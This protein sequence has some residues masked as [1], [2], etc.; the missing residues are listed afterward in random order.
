[1]IWLLRIL[2]LPVILGCIVISAVFAFEFGWTK[3]ATDVHRWAFALAGGGLDFLKAAM[4]II[5]ATAFASRDKAKGRAAWFVFAW[6]TAISLW[7]AYGTTAGQLAER[8]GNKAVEISKQADAKS[9]RDRLKAERA[10]MPA[11]EI[12]TVDSIQAADSAVQA[13]QNAVEAADKAVTQECGRVGDNCRK[14]QGEA[15]DRRA[16]LGKAITAKTA[17]IRDKGATDKAADLEQQ[18]KAAEAALAKVDV[19]TMSVEADPQSASMSKATGWD[20]NKIVLFS[21]LLFA[22]GI[23]AGSGFGLWMLMGH[24]IAKRDEDEEDPI[25]P[26]LP[27]VAASNPV[28]D[29]TPVFG[30][31]AHFFKEA[32][33]PDDGKRVAS[34]IMYRGYQA[35]CQK[36][37]V[38]PL[39]P[40]VFGKDSPWPKEKVGGTVYYM[41]AI[42][43]PGYDA[44]PNLRVVASGDGRQVKAARCA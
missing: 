24:G 4:P 31:R 8:I 43:A 20:E 19:K 5:A 25:Q 35:W 44:L 6:L 12:A 2:L 3:G 23:E 41:Q 13:A 36:I 1:M 7:C 30:S 29:Q 37:G 9:L 32:V 34:A 11:F 42:L 40:Q 22:I 26:E 28:V 39:S 38:E 16:E 21:H 15:T 17:M 14:R 33:I 18:I 27:A 10:S